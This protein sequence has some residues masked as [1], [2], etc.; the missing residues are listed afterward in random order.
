MPRKLPHG[1][2]TKKFLSVDDISA[3]EQLA[4]ICERYEHTRLRISWGMLQTRP[5]DFPLDFLYYDAGK[6]VGYVALDD[7]G[8][9]SKE[10]FGMVHPAH[11]R[12]GIFQLLFQSALDV[13]Y[14]R[15]VK[16]LILTCEHT[17]PSGQAFIKSVG[18]TYDFSEHEMVLTDFRPRHQFDD[19]LSIQLADGDDSDALVF[20]QSA[21]FGD[22][23]T[24]VHWRIARFMHNPICRYYIMMLEKE[25][26]GFKE[27]IGSLRLELDDE[28]GIYAFG[29][30]PTYQGRGYGRQMLEEVIH[31]IRAEPA[32]S[33][34]A[35][36]LDVETD[37]IHAFNLYRSCGFQV[38]ATYD[39]YNCYLQ[40]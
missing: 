16:H 19:R 15:G 34:K 24:V 38:R 23:E 8:V 36:M 17:S 10:L 22:S 14:S 29:V 6:I 33:Q 32:I 27:P 40:L 9:E 5:G 21:A 28:I 18:A 13:C 11:R 35:I 3:I 12:Q 37:N 25:P 20:V 26:I 4:A 31:L 30:H 7:R 2:V 39:Y 1:I